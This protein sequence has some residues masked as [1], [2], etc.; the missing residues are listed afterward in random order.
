MLICLGQESVLLDPREEAN[1]VRESYGAWIKYCLDVAWRGEVCLALSWLVF[2]TLNHTWCRWTLGS[3]MESVSLL[4][5][6][7]VSWQI[8]EA[9][10]V[11]WHWLATVE[12]VT[13]LP[14][15][16][17]TRISFLV[18]AAKFSL[19]FSPG[20]SKHFILTVS[21]GAMWLEGFAIYWED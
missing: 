6:W 4:L 11:T 19:L 17:Y 16:P 13:C 15:S 1:Q 8:V 10:N 12:N 18:T 9:P 20:E 21:S 3:C 14:L 7:W 5:G 2:K